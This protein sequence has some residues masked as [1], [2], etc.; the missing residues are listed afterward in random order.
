MSKEKEY[1]PFGATRDE[2]GKIV[3]DVWIKWAHEQ[4][5][6]KT[7]WFVPYEELTEADKEVDRRI[8]E[9]LYDLGIEQG[10]ASLKQELSDCQ[11]E[12]GNLQAELFAARQEL[13][14][15]EKCSFIGAMRDCPTHGESARLKE[16]EQENQIL[17]EELKEARAESG[18]FGDGA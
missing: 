11:T 4:R 1:Q 5:S 13:A 18:R 8:G 6:Q 9:T 12:R 14:E 7:S 16:L 15:R 3:R 2:V 10:K 17:I